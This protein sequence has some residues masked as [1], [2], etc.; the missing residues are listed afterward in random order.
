MVVLERVR[1][2]YKG[3]SDALKVLF[4][5]REPVSRELSLYNHLVRENF[6]RRPGSWAMDVLSHNGGI[7]SFETYLHDNILP[8]IQQSSETNSGLYAM[9]LQRW[10]NA[11]YATRIYVAS[12]DDF[13]RNQTEFLPDFMSFS[14]YL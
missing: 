13:K 14:I 1:A 10:F 7:M 12:Y 4:M 11:F 2:T 6:K 8:S 3:S 5:L 9:W